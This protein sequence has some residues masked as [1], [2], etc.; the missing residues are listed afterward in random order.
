MGDFIKSLESVL[1]EASLDSISLFGSRLGRYYVDIHDRVLFSVVGAFKLAHL[2]FLLLFLQSVG[3]LAATSVNLKVLYVVQRLRYS[4]GQPSAC[5]FQICQIGLPL[6]LGD[7]HDVIGALDR[8]RVNLPRDDKLSP[9]I[10]H[11][12]LSSVVVKIV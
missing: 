9:C 6:F 3:C 4:C 7:I 10:L 11:L 5:S 1:Y 2:R 8:C 12:S